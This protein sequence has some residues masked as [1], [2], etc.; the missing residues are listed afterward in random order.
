MDYK[1][2]TLRMN[3]SL[4]ISLVVAML[5]NLQLFSHADVLRGHLVGLADRD[6]IIVLDEKKQRHV[7]RLMGID[8]PEKVQAFGQKAKQ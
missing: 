3:L 8:A 5:V 4:A 1:E 2:V 7:V 6:T